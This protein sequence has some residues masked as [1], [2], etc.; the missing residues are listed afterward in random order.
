MYK[1]LKNLNKVI[2]LIITFTTLILPIS[3]LAKDKEASNSLRY[4]IGSVVN[5][6]KDT[7]YSESNMLDEDDP[8]YGWTIGDF[9][10]EGYTS[11]STDKDNNPIFLKNVGDKVG[12][13]FNLEQDINKLNGQD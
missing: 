2:L 4:Y 13:Y 5:T 3:P 11:T 12:L 1:K 9:F 10:V 6:G 8:H 7:G